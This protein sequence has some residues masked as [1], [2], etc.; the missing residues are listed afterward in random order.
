MK[1]YRST[2]SRRR[3]PPACTRGSAGAARGSPPPGALRSARD[4]YCSGG[5]SASII[6]SMT[7]NA[8]VGTTRSRIAGLPKGRCLPSGLGIHTR[9]TGL[10]RYVLPLRCSAR[11]PSPRSTPH[12]ALAAKFR[13]S[14]SGAPPLTRRGPTRPQDTPCRARRGTAGSATPWLWRAAPPATSE[15]F[16]EGLPHHPVPSSASLPALT[17]PAPSLHGRYPLPRYDGPVR[18]PAR[19]G[20][21]RAGVRLAGQ[22]RRPDRRAY[23]RPSRF[24]R[25]HRRAGAPVLRLFSWPTCRRHYPG[26]PAKPGCSAVVAPRREG[27][28]LHGGGL[29][30]GTTGSASASFVSRLA[31]R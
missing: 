10:G 20:L 11:S 12:A 5:R 4:A 9:R 29:R 31:R 22:R 1:G 14:T 8:A 7:N 25:C 13:P 28:G 27:C 21:T 15:V 2:R 16:P 18:L 26:G 30:L 17:R 6:G 19:P 3:Q 23:A 24:R